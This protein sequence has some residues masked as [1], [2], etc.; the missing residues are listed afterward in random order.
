MKP[1]HKYTHNYAIITDGNQIV[2]LFNDFY[3][4]IGPTLANKIPKSD[5]SPNYYSKNASVNAQYNQHAN[6]EELVTILR[7][8]KDATCGADELSLKIIKM[9]INFITDPLLHVCNTSL[10]CFIFP[11]EIEIAKVVP[12][13]KNG[14]IMRFT[15]HHPLSISPDLSGVLERLI[16]HRLLKFINKYQILYLYQIGFQQKHSNLVALAAFIDRA[17]GFIDNGEYAIGIYLYFSKAFDAMNHDILFMKLHHYGVRGL[18]LLWFKSYMSDRLRYVSYNHY[19]STLQMRTLIIFS[20]WSNA[21]L[22]FLCWWFF[23]LCFAI[24]HLF[25]PRYIIRWKSNGAQ[26][27][28]R[29]VCCSIS[30]YMNCQ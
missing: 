15:N 8:L 13:Y 17:T 29:G 5:I 9:S 10:S 27:T 28:H 19:D 16:Y 23:L 26:K 25:L 12:I 3:M 4:N 11:A 6:K 22:F 14:D 18:S 1:N 30:Y 20:Y 21:L 24:L 2:I 7:S